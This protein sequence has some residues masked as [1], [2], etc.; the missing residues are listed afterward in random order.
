[1]V[2]PEIA[3][4][5]RVAS[6]RAASGTTDQPYL[7]C[8]FAIRVMMLALPVR[9]P[10]PFTVPW[11]CITPASTA[12]MVF[13][14]AQ[15]VSLWQWT[16]RSTPIAPAAV[17]TSPICEGS[18]PPLVS[19]STTTSAPASAATRTHSSAYDGLSW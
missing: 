2:T 8:R 15:P 11:M 19:H 16:P 9:S 6:R 4:L 17:T 7:S 10:W 14:T 5:S 12:A 1:M 3:W 18:M 13:A